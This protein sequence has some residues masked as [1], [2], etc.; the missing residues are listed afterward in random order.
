MNVDRTYPN[1]AKELCCYS[2]PSLICGAFFISLVAPG[3]GGFLTG[4]DVFR[5]RSGSQTKLDRFKITAKELPLLIEQNPR[6]I[7]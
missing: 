6:S 3:L 4:L 2:S 1:L 5:H 7:C